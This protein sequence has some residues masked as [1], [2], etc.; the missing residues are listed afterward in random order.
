MKVYRY[1]TTQRVDEN[2]LKNDE[3]ILGVMSL[4]RPKYLVL[5]A[6]LSF[7]CELTDCRKLFT[8]ARK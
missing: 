7:Y 6:E 4:V 5:F 3:P 8:L 2:I 1:K